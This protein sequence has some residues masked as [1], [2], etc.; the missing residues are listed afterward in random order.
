MITAKVMVQSKNE[1][2]VDDHRQ[3]IVTFNADYNDGRNKEWSPYTPTL[4][5]TMTLKGEVADMFKVGQAFT[6]QFVEAE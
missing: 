5:L 2:G 1:S 4:T 3:V 6:L